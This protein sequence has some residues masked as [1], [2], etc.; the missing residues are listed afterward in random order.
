[1][2]YGVG[3]NMVILLR[4]YWDYLTIVARAGGYF[5]LAFGYPFPPTLFNVLVDA[6]ICHWVT[7]VAPTAGRLEGRDLLLGKLAAYLY[8]DDGIIASTQPERLQR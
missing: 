2:V 1:M 7:V 8:A 5:G 4:T 3:P 6:I